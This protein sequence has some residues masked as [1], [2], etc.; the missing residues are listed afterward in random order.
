MEH[1]SSNR[2]KGFGR[3]GFFDLPTIFVMIRK[4]TA[5]VIRKRIPVIFL[6]SLFVASCETATPN[7]GPEFF[8]EP[9]ENSGVVVFSLSRS[10]SVL[11]NDMG[12]HYRS[13]DRSYKGWIDLASIYEEKN[14]NLPAPDW[15]NK[16][17]EQGSW[18][19]AIPLD[20]PH[21]RLV[22]IQLPADEYEFYSWIGV[23]S[24]SYM[25]PA[26][27]FS[28]KFS[29]KPGKIIYLGGIVLQN[30]VT[31]S[32]LHIVDP[33][34]RDIAVLANKYPQIDLNQVEIRIMK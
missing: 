3:L 15:T 12:F 9:P 20:S 18:G 33:R 27:E 8:S 14:K 26:K 5:N 1:I 7:I 28:I 30:M 2:F 11:Y 4:R 24:N 34:K 13:L 25:E 6:A 17:M 16:T 23:S 31:E 10:G 32:S 29:V 21:G 19:T 22:V